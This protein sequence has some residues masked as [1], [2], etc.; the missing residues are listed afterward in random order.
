MQLG[1]AIVY[2]HTALLHRL[3]RDCCGCQW[4]PFIEYLGNHMRSNAVCQTGGSC[5]LVEG[6]GN[7]P[8]LLFRTWHYR[9]HRRF[10]HRHAVQR[11]W[12]SI[13]QRTS[14]TRCTCKWTRRPHI[15]SRLHKMAQ[16][17]ATHTM[18]SLRNIDRATCAYTGDYRKHTVHSGY[19]GFFFEYI[20]KL[21]DFPTRRV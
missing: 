17:T 2:M 18:E 12:M 11:L 14:N 6:R 10:P 3:S 1:S 16:V 9:F 7:S 4:I 21:L 13:A 20:N 15:S 8:S 19:I 5:P